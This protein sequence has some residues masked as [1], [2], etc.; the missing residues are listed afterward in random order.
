MIAIAP[1]DVIREMANIGWIENP[2]ELIEFLKMRNETSHTYREEIAIQVF[3]ASKA[4]EKTAKEI[5]QILK[6]KAT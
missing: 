1:K 6:E 5:L 2:S 4:F 3:E